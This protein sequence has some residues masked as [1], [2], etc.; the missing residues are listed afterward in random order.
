VSS[1]ELLVAA[2]C[3]APP[4][5]T[6]FAENI[7]LSELRGFSLDAQ[8]TRLEK[9]K[10]LNVPK[11]PW[12][13]SRG[14][15]ELQIFV[16][17]SGRMFSRQSYSDA[18]SKYSKLQS[19]AV[20]VKDTE[21]L[22]FDENEGFVH[23]NYDAPPHQQSTYLMITKIAVSRD[24]S[25]GFVCSLSM[26]QVLHLGERQ[27]IKSLRGG[28]SLLVGEYQTFDANCRVQR[29]NIFENTPSN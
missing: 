19:D 12:I 4:T 9:F 29:G 22:R 2:I 8:I 6:A 23:L 5:G 13:W 28:G 25:G 27:F 17:N 15:F 3:C 21:G 24:G 16:A 7:A 18:Y 20:L 26:E 1:W 10:R 11:D 14:V